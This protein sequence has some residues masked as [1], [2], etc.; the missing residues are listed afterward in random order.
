MNFTDL[1]Y[2][3]PPLL[4]ANVWD[5]G[6]AIA[7]QQLGYQACGTS[8]AAI[9]AMLGYDD[10]EGMPFDDLFFIVS[11][12]CAVTSLP[13]SVD[14]EAGY[15]D[16]VEGVIKNIQ[17]LAQLGVVGINLEDSRVV[18][19]ERR[20]EEPSRFAARLSAIRAACPE[21]FINVRT[22]TFLLD[23]PQPLE[24]T[25]CR[26]RMYAECGAQGFF[27]PGVTGEQ[28]IVSIVREVALP[29]NVMCMPELADFPTLARWG[30]KRISMGNFVHGALQSALKDLLSGVQAAQ[31]FSG[32]FRHADH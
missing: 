8:S 16:T 2:Q 7:A 31:S 22:D 17:R 1:H 14:M 15:S 30:V 4:I 3:N 19:G 12:L 26:G 25:L 29:L 13:L 18:Q 20:L 9:A 27:V 24:E 10:G 21:L 32:V 11:R 23:I 28:E 5:A 6:S